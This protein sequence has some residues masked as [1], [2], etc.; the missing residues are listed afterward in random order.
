[1]Q[2]CFGIIDKKLNT[3]NLDIA[4]NS[5][6]HLLKQKTLTKKNTDNNYLKIANVID[7]NAQFEYRFISPLL[8]SKEEKN[9][10]LLY[11]QIVKFKKKRYNSFE[12][13]RSIV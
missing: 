13:Y 1:M 2:N 6:F 7:K 3:N 10:N 8:P 12:L 4:K 5:G 11:T 9:S